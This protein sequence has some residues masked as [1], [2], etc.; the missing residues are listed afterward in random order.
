MLPE[1]VLKTNMALKMDDVSQLLAFKFTNSSFDPEKYVRDLSAQ[2]DT[3]A[4]LQD[5]RKR[6]QTLS[7]E[8]AV[9]LK[10]NVYK[11]YMQF[12][13]TSKEISYLEAE[14]YQLGHFL[15]EQKSI[16]SSQQDMSLFGTQD[17]SSSTKPSKKDEKGSSS[18][19]SVEGLA[20][21]LDI[22]D[23]NCVFEGDLVEVDPET[24]L[25][26][27]KVHAFL[28]HD[29]MVVANIIQNRRGPVRFKYQC[30]FELENVAV[31][32]MTSADGLKDAFKIFLF[33][34]THVYQAESKQI[35]KEWLDRIEECKKNFK[36]K[37]EQEF[38][39]GDIQVESEGTS[40]HSVNT[41]PFLDDDK[42][43]FTNDD[44][45][46]SKNP[47]K[48]TTSTNP[49][50]DDEEPIASSSPASTSSKLIK[51]GK[52]WLRDLPEDL[53]MFIAQRD[54]ERAMELIDRT[55]Q[56]LKENSSSQVA[57][58]IKVR[59]DRRVKLLVDALIDELDCSR[60][61]LLHV[62]PRAT[63]RAVSL[64][65][66]L[67]RAS[68]ACQLF[69]KNRSEAIKHSLRQLKIEGATSLYISK[70]SSAF[71]SSVIETGKEF[72]QVFSANRGFSSAFV[73]WANTELQHFVSRFSCQVFRREMGVAAIG[74]CVSMAKQQCE[75]LHEIGLDLTF[76]MQQMLLRDIVEA[77]LDTRDQMVKFARH[78]VTEANWKPMDFEGQ[79]DQLGTLCGEMESL[80]VENFNDLIV[81]G[82]KVDLSGATVTFIKGVLGFLAD[83][84]SVNTPQLQ[85]VF[86]DC[87]GDLFENQVV[88]F[89]AILKSGRYVNQVIYR[90]VPIQN[91]H[92]TE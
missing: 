15:A 50:D 14:M 86:V 69:L 84:L 55:N 2:C 39:Q 27:S 61:F 53:D 17:F 89:E 4:E 81:G 51:V 44:D 40:A 18:I 76:S 47:F 13:E 92:S 33:P 57:K 21:V 88:L 60:S 3:D 46:D 29:S 64:L 56:Y 12:I 41:N 90:K 67:G 16:L 70:L 75:K 87:I 54:F 49:F 36:L 85:P 11:N 35:K 73:V 74:V 63:R 8:T 6:I 45:D 23:V 38:S 71:F 34:E 72:D 52:A 68:E 32:N 58:E 9:S 80:G 82:N 5:H 37:L 31:V 66:R 59:L 30:L 43:P 78:R 10:K 25:P 26:R 79:T 62:G 20:S 22:T 24:F 77:L 65:V 83:G 28:L 7:E 91:N 19:E 48:E 42:N 1:D